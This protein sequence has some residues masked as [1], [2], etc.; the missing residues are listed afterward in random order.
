MDYIESKYKLPEFLSKL[1]EPVWL[2]QGETEGLITQLMMIDN[3]L[4]L[5]YKKE[6]IKFNFHDRGVSLTITTDT[7]P[8]KTISL[9]LTLPFVK[10]LIDTYLLHPD[11]VDGVPSTINNEDFKS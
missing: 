8:N 1:R 6:D 9:K 11:W 3:K 5:G 2:V 4:N 10:S 7:E